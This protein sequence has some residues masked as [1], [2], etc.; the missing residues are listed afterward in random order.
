MSN[1]LWKFTAL[2]TLQ[3]ILFFEQLNQLLLC[4][5]RKI[6]IERLECAACLFSGCK[7]VHG[8]G[9]FTALGLRH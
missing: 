2:F 9:Q 8:I 6:I 1:K 5:L 4:I 7:E 3:E